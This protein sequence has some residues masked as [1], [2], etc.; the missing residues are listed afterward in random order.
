VDFEAKG[1][2]KR[3][4]TGGAQRHG[5]G[6]FAAR[7]WI[8]GTL[9][10]L[11]LVV[12]FS[13][14]GAGGASTLGG[15][16][17]SQDVSST[18]TELLPDLNP[19]EPRAPQ[20]EFSDGH[21]VVAFGT[22][23][24][25]LGAGPVIVTG[26]RPDVTTQTMVASQIVNRSDGTTA[27]YPGVGNLVYV[28]QPD[29]QHWHFLGFM[30]YELRAVG[31]GALVRP[32]QKTGFCL[33]DSYDSANFDPKHDPPGKPPAPV[34]T[35][36]CGL[37]DPTALALEEGVSVGYGDYY[38]PLLE[39][40]SIDLTGVANG[41]YYLVVRVNESRLLRESD[42]ANN[43]SAIQLSLRHPSGSAGKPAMKILATCRDADHCLAP[44]ALHV[45]RLGKLVRGARTVRLRETLSVASIVDVRV[46]LGS[47][48]FS[49]M[50]KQLPAGASTLTVRIPR[51]VA[52]PRTAA[53]YV[54]AGGPGLQPA[55]RTLSIRLR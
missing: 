40:Q 13:F 46:R 54:R 18:A 31:T 10:V 17:S 52:K 3:V 28:V 35:E 33:S 47:R 51:S 48:T 9:L 23:A 20:I 32:S 44:L 6:R 16:P 12:A 34:F 37:G 15:A 21:W 50:R 1:E 19:L 27:V 53:V 14:V 45:S 36:H 38:N 42:Y 4:R 29:H 49:H 5:G 55:L 43:D 41:R 39:G 7:H 26:S 25:N 11:C 2:G 24:D 22:A 8:S 30:T